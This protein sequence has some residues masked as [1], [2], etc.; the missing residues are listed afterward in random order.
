MS[1]A[2]GHAATPREYGGPEKWNLERSEFR[3]SLFTAFEVAD[4]NRVADARAVSE[5]QLFSIR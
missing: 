1:E 5:C 4:Q 3:L 2:A